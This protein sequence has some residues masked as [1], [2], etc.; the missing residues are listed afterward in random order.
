MRHAGSRQRGVVVLEFALTF[1]VFWLVFIG[2]VEF[3]RTVLTWNAAQEVTRM[4]ARYASICDKNLSQQALIM[5][6]LRYL[7]MATGQVDVGD[8][9]DWL[10]FD[11]LPTGCSDASCQH[12]QVRLNDVRLSLMLSGF[13]GFPAEVPLPPNQI[14]VMRETM[15]NYVATSTSSSNLN[16]VCQPTF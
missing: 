1:V 6:R 2:V 4:A 12:V 10:Q 11:Y 13:P 5:G 14:T 8:R 9:L 15:R 16:S 7:I 3:A